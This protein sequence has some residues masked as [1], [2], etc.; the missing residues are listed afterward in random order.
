LLKK[1]YK[2]KLKLNIGCGL[3]APLDWVNI[4]N[5]FTARLSKCKR[6]YKIICKILNIEVISWPQN[7]II[8][9]VRKGL[10]FPNNSSIAI[11]CSHVLEHM[12]FEDANFVI[13]ECYRCL[14]KG[15]V[16]RIIVP[17]LYQ[18]TKKY[19]NNVLSDLNGLHAHT[20]LKELN[21]LDESHKGIWK[22]IYKIFGHSK[23]LYMYDEW[24]LEEVLKKY[25]FTMIQRMDYCKSRILDIKMVEDKERYK[26]AVCIEGVKE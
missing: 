21:I 22:F 2:E 10:P 19:N 9:D 5:S 3:K 8:H 11:F 1:I 7:I 24:S 23:H 13:K 4:D 16:I 6:V 20:F 15:G 25:K 26:M 17:D 18:I 12:S 14:C